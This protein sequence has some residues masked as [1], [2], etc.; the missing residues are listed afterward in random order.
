VEAN[1]YMPLPY[2]HEQAVLAL[3]EATLDDAPEKGLQMLRDLI[4]HIEALMAPPEPAAPPMPAGP[5][6]PMPAGPPALGPAPGPGPM[7]AP[8]MG[9]PVSMAG[10]GG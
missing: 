6:G 10:V 5:P 1:Q 9:P 4:G 8:P 3:A 7:P 2:A